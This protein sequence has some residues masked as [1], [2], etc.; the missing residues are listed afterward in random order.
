MVRRL[1][2]TVKLV[3]E[4][5]PI[6]PACRRLAGRRLA[7]TAIA[8]CTDVEPDERAPAEPT[9]WRG[10]EHVSRELVPPLRQRL[11][12][13]TGRPFAMSWGVRMDEQVARVWGSSVWAAEE[14]G[15]DLRALAA[16]GDQIGVHVHPWRWDDEA[17]RWTVDHR[18]ASAARAVTDGLDAY[19]AAFGRPAKA[20]RAG[21]GAMSGAMLEVLAA[22][23]L[24]VDTTLEHGVTQWK[25]FEGET[26]DGEPFDSW[27]VPT[28]PFRSSPATFPDP[29]PTSDA[30][31][32]LMP[33]TG[34]PARRGRW[35]GTLV[36]GTHPTFFAVRLLGIL[37]RRR[38]RVLVFAVRGDEELIQA[39][40]VVVKNL[41]HLARHEGARFTTVGEAAALVG[42]PSSGR[43]ES[44]EVHVLN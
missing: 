44:R 16:Q 25:P 29:D 15:E 8:F 30:D 24:D 6:V 12:Q 9:P 23:G 31:P 26:V 27:R 19:E 35:A 4:T 36:P 1:K 7:G 5:L 28:G 37:L 41:E 13:L 40:D 38:P 39:W 33:L 10:F 21:D 17:G 22:R 2:R 32:L 18:P 42:K 43:R 11:S 34:G 3:L 14:Y 20:F